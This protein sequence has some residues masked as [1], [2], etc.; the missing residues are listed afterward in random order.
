MAGHAD[1]K[2]AKEAAEESS[3]YCLTVAITVGVYAISRM[4]LCLGYDSCMPSLYEYLLVA[5]SFAVLNAAHKWQRDR[6]LLGVRSSTATDLYFVSLASLLGGS[7]HPWGWAVWLTVPLYCLY[8]SG[9]K[10][11]NWVFT[12]DVPEDQTPE[13]LAFRKKQQKLERRAKSGR[14]TLLQR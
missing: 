8:L 12:P 14:Y 4:L 3:K 7:L 11:L 9:S 6:L 1:K 10:L 13:A 5:F 2:R